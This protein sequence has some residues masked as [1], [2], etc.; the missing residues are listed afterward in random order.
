MDEFSRNTDWLMTQKSEISE[1]S[2]DY[3]FRI[4]QQGF[5]DVQGYSV[6]SSDCRDRERFDRN[7]LVLGSKKLDFFD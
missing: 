3:L 1:Q 4:C 2:P 7:A 5:T 6:M